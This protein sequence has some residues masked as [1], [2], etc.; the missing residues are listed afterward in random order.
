MKKFFVTGI[1]TGVGKTIVSAVLV[2]ALQADYWKPIQAGN[3]EDSDTKTIRRL[4]SNSVSTIH[5]EAYRLTQPLSPHAAAQIDNVAIDLQ[6][7][8]SSVPVTQN[9]HLIIEGAGGAMSPV[10]ESSVMIDLMQGLEASIVVVSQHYLGSINHTLLTIDALKKRNLPLHGIIFNGEPNKQSED[11]IV[12]YSKINMLG[13]VGKEKIL[14]KEIISRYASQ[15]K[16][17]IH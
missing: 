2:E 6:R 13:F 1:G 11:F 4:V 17:V 7:L 16:K 15:F 9:Q 14:T 5:P 10:N 12:S 8:C 3:L